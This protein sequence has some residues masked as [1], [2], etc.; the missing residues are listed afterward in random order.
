MEKK[1]LDLKAPKLQ[2]L[3][4]VSLA[5]L[6]SFFKAGRVNSHYLIQFYPGVL[7]ILVTMLNSVKWPSRL[8]YP[9]WAL[10]LLVLL[11]M[12]GYIEYGRVVAHTIQTGSPYNGEGFSVPAKIREAGL[13]TRHILF[14]GYHIG[15]W[16]LG[17]YPP[18]KAATHPS[19]LV[20]EE[21][22][23]AYGNPR[24]T[25]LDE[26]RYIMETLRPKTI[27]VR[28]GRRIFDKEATAENNYM[29]KYLQKYYRVRESVEQADILERL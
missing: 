17:E 12:E 29:D 25:A 19:N 1:L 9:K 28:R 26:L 23:K 24:E 8:F 6:Y 22:F 21:M 20:K 14:L 27:V 13:E 11:P 2:V 7:L 10:G 3:V 4:L 15:Y 5:V 18:T 16:V